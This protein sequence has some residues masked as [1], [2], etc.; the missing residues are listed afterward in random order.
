VTAEVHVLFEGYVGDRTAS[1]VSLVLDGDQRIV[2][3][4]GMVPDQ[5]AI[6]GPLA[7]LSVEPGTV[8]DVVLSHHHP[9]HTMNA[10]LF[11][12]ARVHDHWATYTGDLW[13]SRPAEGFRVS[14]SVSL[15]ET[16]GHTA[17][18]LST[19]VETEEGL[20]AFTHLWWNE[21]GPSEDPLA[22]DPP[23]LHEQ[24][25]RVLGLGVVRVVPGHGAA[26]APG[27][28]TPR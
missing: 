5:A 23:A 24:R 14:P 26:F 18:D 27:P 9:D 4:P 13:E 3:D 28:E 19:V 21:T 7:A 8:T 1:T 11:P 16:R 17:Q 12:A 20:V 2:I 6:L 15:L 25:V 22:E 10:G